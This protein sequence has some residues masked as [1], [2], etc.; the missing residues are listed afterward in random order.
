LNLPGT[1]EYN[2][3]LSWLSKM[4]ADGCMACDV[5]EFVDDERVT[6]PD[7][8]LTWQANHALASKQSLLGIQDAG[9][10]ARPCSQKPGAWAGGIVHV[11]SEL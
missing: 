3:C 5:F 11:V 2:P 9:R 7:E 6:G 10:K 4:C 8:E 1:R